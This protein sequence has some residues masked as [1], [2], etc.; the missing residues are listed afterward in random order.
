M[1]YDSLLSGYPVVELAIQDIS[2]K[3][4]ALK[5]FPPQKG[6]GVIVGRVND[7]ETVLLSPRAAAAVS[8]G[9]DFFVMK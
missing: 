7:S 4:I 9:R 2:K 5:I 6:S 1:R 3:N 8:R